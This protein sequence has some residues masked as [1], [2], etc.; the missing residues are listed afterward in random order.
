VLSSDACHLLMNQQK[1]S[2]GINLLMISLKK[3]MINSSR[4]NKPSLIQGKGE[5]YV[6]DSHSEIN[7]DLCRAVCYL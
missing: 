6:V 2:L 3:G 5:N 7:K 1:D 4:K